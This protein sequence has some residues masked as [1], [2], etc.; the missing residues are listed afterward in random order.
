MAVDADGILSAM[1]PFTDFHP[2]FVDYS[3]H[4]LFLPPPSRDKLPSMK[5]ASTLF[6]ILIPLT[7]FLLQACTTHTPTQPPATDPKAAAI[8]P[9]DT[10]RLKSDIDNVAS[11]LLSDKPDTTK[12]KTAAGDVLSTTAAVLS[13][14]GINRLTDPSDPSQKAA[15]DA[16][17]KLRDAGGLTPGAL[18]SLKKAADLLKSN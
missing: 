12:L 15:G 1:G 9:I 6:P 7:C 11:S 10:T 14:T 2:P 13:D 5:K 3:Y 8:T 17:K 18:D 4:P 16:L